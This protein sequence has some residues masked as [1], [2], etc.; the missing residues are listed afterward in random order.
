MSLVKLLYGTQLVGP[1]NR[2]W[3]WAQKVS[4][5][6][7][8]STGT[9]SAVLLFGADLAKL[10]P[11]PAFGYLLP[12]TCGGFS[13][14]LAIDYETSLVMPRAGT[15]RSLQG[16]QVFNGDPAPLSGFIASVTL[17]KN[18]VDTLLAVSNVPAGDAF[19]N[20]AV[21]V[22]CDPGD[23]ISVK[24]VVDSYTAALDA[25]LSVFVEFA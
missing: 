4:A 20:T 5:K 7:D 10:Q 23:L 18:S 17:R 3:N 16:S 1:G 9:G 15:L 19:S 11:G 13:G 8:Q 21:E 6:A 25:L 24:V 12:G 2:F 22:S 14:S